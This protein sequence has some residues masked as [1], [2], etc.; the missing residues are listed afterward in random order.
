MF[1]LNTTTH[2]LIMHHT[3]ENS[4]RVLPHIHTKQTVLGPLRL[5][6]TQDIERSQERPVLRKQQYSP[7]SHVLERIST[8]MGPVNKGTINRNEWTVFEILQKRVDH[9]QVLL[10]V[11]V[12]FHVYLS[13]CAPDFWYDLLIYENV[14]IKHALIMVNK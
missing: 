14:Q 2:N 11:Y 13:Q 9:F 10:T 7:G 8:V 12:F 4:W 1:S 6:P 5:P 3:L